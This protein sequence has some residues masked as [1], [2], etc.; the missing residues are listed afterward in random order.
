MVKR[1]EICGKKPQD[2]EDCRNFDTHHI[3]FQ[4][5]ANEMGCV[6]DGRRGR[7]SLSNL[8]ILCKKDHSRVHSGEIM[9]DGWKSTS[10]G[11]ILDWCIIENPKPNTGRQERLGNQVLTPELL[12]SI[13]PLLEEGRK[14][15]QWSRII[16]LLRWNFRIITTK[17]TINKLSLNSHG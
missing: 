10:K 1:C 7:D 15:N 17:E 12:E 5:T 2:I 8:V 6:D 9:I 13:K 11:R 14:T 16:N 3:L 4:S